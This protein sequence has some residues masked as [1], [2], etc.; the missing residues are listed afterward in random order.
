VFE[1]S[2]KAGNAPKGIEALKGI[3]SCTS[4]PVYAIGGIDPGNSSS[5][6]K[7]GAVGICSLTGL[8]SA[9]D[10]AKIISQ[11]RNNE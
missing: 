9:E 8:M 11:L 2:C 5:V 3:C 7:A 10:P 6:Y 4:L 1:N